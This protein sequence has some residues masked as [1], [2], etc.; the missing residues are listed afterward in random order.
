MTKRDNTHEELVRFSRVIALLFNR[1]TIY[2]ASHPYVTQTIEDFYQGIEQILRS[3]SPLVF[4]MNH[5]QFFLDDQPFHSGTNVGRIVAYFKK[6]GIESISFDSGITKN[7]IT[8]FLEIFTS[9]DAYPTADAMK[10][11]LATRGVRHMKIN[12]VFFKKVT[13]DEEVVSHDALKKLT[14]GVTEEDQRK[15]KKLFLDMI[16]GSLMADELRGTL[17]LK[18]LMASP[19]ALTNRMTEADRIGS[20]NTELTG[21][22]PGLVLL[23]QLEILGDEVKMALQEDQGVN[24]PALAS[25]VFEMKKRLTENIETQKSLQ[26]SYANEGLILQKVNEISDDVIL[27]IISKEY[28]SGEISTARL[29]QIVRRLIPEQDELK[30]LLPQIKAAL[31]KDGMPVEV[32]LDF[33]RELGKDLQSEDLVGVLRE[34]SEELGID[35]EALVEEIMRNP[36]NAAELVYMA[37]EIRKG[38][39]DEQALSDLLMNYV[40]RLGCKLVTKESEGSEIEGEGHL[41]KVIK[42]I[43]S[44]LIGRLKNMEIQNDLVHRLEERFNERM[45]E[46]LEKVKLD[47]LHSQSRLPEKDSSKE[48][49]VLELLEQSVGEGDDLGEILGVVR[50]KVEANEMDRNDFSRIYAEIVEQQKRRDAE[51]ERKMPSGVFR[52]PIL[53]AIIEREIARAERYRLPFSALSFSLVRVVPK[54]VGSAVKISYRELMATLLQKVSGVARNSDIIGEFGKNRIVVLL[55]MTPENEAR[56]ALRRYMK[57]LHGSSFEIRDILVSIRLAG[58][59]SSYDPMSTTNAA[60]FVENLTNE[61]VHMEKRIKNIQAYF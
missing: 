46:I 28:G 8:V 35:G 56:L 20:Q 54:S 12:H 37:S 40:E 45:D 48:L 10:K 47:W 53:R 24:L 1:A 30:R 51:L 33:A 34:C 14:P 39:G 59:S 52:A 38:S 61:L 13:Q 7:E 15:S 29:A 16:L 49:S 4:I 41:R 23:H 18:N 11:A 21:E 26:I 44:N 55:P 6:V 17:T 31:I 57:Q 3:I 25:A 50:A 22:R 27:R 42:S 19:S 58:V 9:L 36:Q 32:Y 2:H 60:A 43:E 5:D